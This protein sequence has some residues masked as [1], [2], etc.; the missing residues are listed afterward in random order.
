MRSRSSRRLQTVIATATPPP[1]KLGMANKIPTGR[2]SSSLEVLPSRMTTSTTNLLSMDSLRRT[3]CTSC[4]Q[5]RYPRIVSA[6]LRSVATRTISTHTFPSLPKNRFFDHEYHG[7]LVPSRICSRQFSQSLPRTM[8]NCT[9]YATTTCN[10]SSPMSS[11]EP[12]RAWK[13]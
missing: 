6:W 12:T 11:P 5:R 2:R 13:L 3:Q 8:K 4:L 10:N 9:R 7:S 1:V